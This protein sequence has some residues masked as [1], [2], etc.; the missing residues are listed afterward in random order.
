MKK[1]KK[2]GALIK[3]KPRRRFKYAKYSILKGMR[4][5]EDGRF[6]KILNQ[7]DYKTSNLKRKCPTNH[8]PCIF[9]LINPTMNTL[10]PSFNADSNRF[11]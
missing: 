1:G 10:S 3:N 9:Q 2:T 7:H 4:Q 6:E 8:Q 5:E 11:K